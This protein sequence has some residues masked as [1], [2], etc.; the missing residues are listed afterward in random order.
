VSDFCDGERSRY[1]ERQARY[2]RWVG[3]SPRTN[4]SLE[5]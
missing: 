4:L 5:E 3:S 2:A 1:E